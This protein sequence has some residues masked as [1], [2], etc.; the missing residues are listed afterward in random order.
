MPNKSIKPLRLI[1]AQPNLAIALREQD[2][3]LHPENFHQRRQGALRVGVMLGAGLF[4]LL[5]KLI[6]HHD[7]R[8]LINQGRQNR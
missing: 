6:H 2:A 5:A 1:L 7:V 3:V 8:R 4:Q